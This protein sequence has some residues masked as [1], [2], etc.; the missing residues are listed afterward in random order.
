MFIRRCGTA[1]FGR[2]E[3]GP[4]SDLTVDFG[5]PLPIMCRVNI[6]NSKSREKIDQKL[7]YY[8]EHLNTT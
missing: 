8:I 2:T 5:F 7:T 6:V 3:A 4:A 1:S